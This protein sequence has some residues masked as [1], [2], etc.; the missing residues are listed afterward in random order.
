MS[1]ARYSDTD[2]YTVIT[3]IY[4]TQGSDSYFPEIAVDSRRVASTRTKLNT[5]LKLILA[6]ASVEEV[7]MDLLGELVENS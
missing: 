7:D 2:G 1:I 6:P 4:Q 5:N 3:K